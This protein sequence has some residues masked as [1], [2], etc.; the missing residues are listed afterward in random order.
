MMTAHK[1]V[2]SPKNIHSLT[3][4]LWTAIWKLDNMIKTSG[5]KKFNLQKIV[6]L[7]HIPN[8][9]S[10]HAKILINVLA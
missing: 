2:S 3:N 10:W 8:N 6:I 9:I 5:V 4:K 7:R 1:E